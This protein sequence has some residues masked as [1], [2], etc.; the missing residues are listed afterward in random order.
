MT[1]PPLT[2]RQER[3]L[4]F[5]EEQVA[6]RGYAPTLREIAQ[7][8]DIASLQGVKDHMAALERKGYLRRVPGRRRAIELAAHRR[9]WPSSGGGVPILGQVAAGRPILAVENLEGVLALGPALLGGGTHF[10]LRVRGDSMDGAGIADGDHVVV[11]QQD[12]AD[13][14]DIVV[15]LLGEEVTVKRLRKKGG[16]FLLEAA[17]AAYAPVPLTGSAPAPRILGK[18]VGLYRALPGKWAGDRETQGN[19]N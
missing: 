1:P 18:V 8:M 16:E 9:R 14:G 5:I 4:A 2:P 7:H 19:P 15:A 17:N 10:A 11:L 3:L 6:R 13:P 12:T